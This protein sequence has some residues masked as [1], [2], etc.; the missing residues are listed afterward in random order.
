MDDLESSTGQ[1]YLLTTAIPGGQFLPTN[2][3]E[4]KEIAEIADWINVM[5]YDLNG[6]NE[7]KITNF[8]AAFA[9]SP[10]DPSPEHTRT[11]H[12]VVNSLKIFEDAGVAK[13][14]LVVGVPF[15]GRGFSGVPDINNGLYQSFTGGMGD[16]YGDYRSLK[17]E[18]IPKMTRFW[19]P[20]AKV[21]WLYDAASKRMISYDD[22]ESIGNKAAYVRDNGYGGIMIWELS[23]DDALS[24]LLTAIGDNLR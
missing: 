4:L 11:Y 10:N 6:S 7:S 22:P 1:R 15:Y 17:R 9:S 8:N 12:N 23:D 14:Q 13:H 16:N 5:T 21:P 20:E 19:H 3:F 24:S 2:C 18:L